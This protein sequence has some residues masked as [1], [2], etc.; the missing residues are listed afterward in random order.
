MWEAD[1]WPGW[2]PC[3][4][5]GHILQDVVAALWSWYW[6][7]GHVWHVASDVVVPLS[8]RSPALHVFHLSHGTARPVCGAN[9][10]ARHDWH[11]ELEES[12]VVFDHRPA[13]QR[14]RHW[15]SEL[16]PVRVD[17]F[18]FEQPSHEV[19]LIT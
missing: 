17:H 15:A 5:V 7:D 1:V 11:W 10:P 13:E 9:L 19:A 16:S 3:L 14:P 6:P 4:P 18:P 12:P 2:L 8:H